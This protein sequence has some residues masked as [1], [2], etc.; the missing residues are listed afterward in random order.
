MPGAVQMHSQKKKKKTI[1]INSSFSLFTSFHIVSSISYCNILS[2]IFS[3]LFAVFLILSAH[4]Y[5]LYYSPYGGN[6]Y[7][8]QFFSSCILTTKS[9]LLF[10]CALVIYLQ[11]LLCIWLTM[12]TGVSDEGPK[13]GE[14][15]IAVS[16]LL[17]FR[18]VSKCEG[19]LFD[20]PFC[21]DAYR[22]V[23]RS[24]GSDKVLRFSFAFCSCYT[25]AFE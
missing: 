10:F 23:S 7:S 4:S 9:N 13:C 21:F 24:R 25:S 17:P 12:S 22:S 3:S 11:T 14:L 2:A 16:L 6:L 19:D 15:N 1:D 18:S 20:F 5:W 8:V